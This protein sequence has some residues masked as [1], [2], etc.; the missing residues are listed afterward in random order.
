MMVNGHMSFSAN[1]EKKNV[2][3]TMKA[4]EAKFSTAQGWSYTEQGVFYNV[5]FTANEHFISIYFD[6]WKKY[7]LHSSR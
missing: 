6:I 2:L 7:Q 5:Q 1:W 4:Y 3:K